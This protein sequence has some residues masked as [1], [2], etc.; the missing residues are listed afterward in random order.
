MFSFVFLIFVIKDFEQFHI[1]IVSSEYVYKCK[2]RTGFIF[3]VWL[4]LNRLWV[5][6][7]VS[8]WY[9]KSIDQTRKIV[10]A[11]F[12]WNWIGDQLNKV[13]LIWRFL[14]N[15]FIINWLII[16]EPKS[17]IWSNKPPNW[18]GRMDLIRSVWIIWL[19]LNA[20][21]WLD[22]F[23]VVINHQLPHLIILILQ[24]QISIGC[25]L[26]ASCV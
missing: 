21:I 15:L 25:L 6:L 12:D 7:D 10:W 1:C 11:Y 24:G 18:P 5:V 26:H 2:L 4:F 14:S 13:C 20:I 23:V 19:K 3:L 8:I 9:S 17:S 16:V 22:Q